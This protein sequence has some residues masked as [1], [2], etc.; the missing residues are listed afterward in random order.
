VYW[1]FALKADGNITK[2]ERIKGTLPNQ[3]GLATYSM[4][5]TGPTE[6]IRGPASG[7][8]WF[9][10]AKQLGVVPDSFG[11]RGEDTLLKLGWVAGPESMMAQWLS[12]GEGE[13]RAEL[14]GPKAGGWLDAMR[15]AVLRD[16]K[17]PNHR[18]LWVIL[19]SGVQ[20]RV[21]IPK[22][23]NLPDYLGKN[24][25]RVFNEATGRFGYADARGI[26]KRAQSA[27]TSFCGVVDD[28]VKL[29]ASGLTG[30]RK[31][32]RVHVAP[33]KDGGWSL[34]LLSAP[35]AEVFGFTKDWYVNRVSAP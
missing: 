6:L 10:I 19:V 12:L 4:D 25:V 34:L 16:L 24:G 5:V 21:D 14:Y 33:V 13:F 26:A 30:A 8:W 15:G 18:N 1:L 17:L 3:G 32:D 28:P 31:G 9:T 23:T 29:G 2:T 35:Q 20:G 7:A 22:E 27:D 11:K